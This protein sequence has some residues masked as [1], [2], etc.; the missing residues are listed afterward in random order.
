[1]KVKLT[2]GDLRGKVV[3]AERSE[4]HGMP[5]WAFELDGIKYAVPENWAVQVL[6]LHYE[7]EK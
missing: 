5:V 7:E 6:N 1:M 2:T 3:E 4:A